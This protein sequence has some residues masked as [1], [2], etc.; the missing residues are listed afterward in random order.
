MWP[1]IISAGASL[2]G[3]AVSAF[4]QSRA[5]KRTEDFSREMYDYALLSG[6]SLEMEGL[7]RAG[8]NPMLRYGSGGSSTPVS[9]PT[10]SFNN[11]YGSLGDAISGA[12]SSAFS[13][14]TAQQGIE[15]SRQRISHS[16]MEMMRIA[17]DTSRIQADTRLT[18]QQRVNAVSE[19]GRILQQTAVGMA[20]EYLRYAQANLSEAQ[21]GQ[22]ASMV[23]LLGQELSTEQERTMLV[24]WQ[25]AV[26][27]AEASLRH[28]EVP[29][30]ELDEQIFRTALGRWLRETFLTREATGSSV[31][32]MIGG[33]AVEA[34]RAVDGFMDW[35]EQATG[36][37]AREVFRWFE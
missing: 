19:N 13:A 8:I 24:Y 5:Q 30:A 6:P 32:G 25:A 17:Q 26:A 18:D 34:G 28:S 2:L 21:A 35:Y 14:L 10:M 23:R 20:E 33:A 15:E 22:A 9:M 12:G 1:A 16:S 31:G 11:A 29:R 36:D 27:E 4:G 7:R 37:A 3:G